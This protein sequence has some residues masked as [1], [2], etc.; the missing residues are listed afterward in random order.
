MNLSIDSA[1]PMN[2]HV[3]KLSVH[4]VYS[5]QK[6]NNKKNTIKT[7]RGIVTLNRKAAHAKNFDYITENN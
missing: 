5:R 3:A 1:S 6:K 4:T 2:R 7:T